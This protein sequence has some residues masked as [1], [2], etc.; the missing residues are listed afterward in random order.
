MSARYALIKFASD[1][2]R[3]QSSIQITRDRTE[4][5]RFLQQETRLLTPEEA[6]LPKVLWVH[7]LFEVR[8]LPPFYR[9]RHI[10]LPFGST[11]SQEDLLAEDLRKTCKLIAPCDLDDETGE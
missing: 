7:W 10:R 5:L 3:M 4:A 2:R 9:K 11:A 8:R 1:P 6:R